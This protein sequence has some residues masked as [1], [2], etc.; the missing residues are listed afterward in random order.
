MTVTRTKATLVG[1][2][3]ILS[4]GLLALLAIGSA[5]VPPMQLNALC[6]AT[7][8]AIGLVWTGF[9]AGFVVLRA[10]PW[11]VYL[12][13]TLGLFGAHFLY[14]TAIRW[15]PMAETSLIGYLWPLFIVLLS[16]L[17]PGEK[18][19]PLHVVGALLAFGG[20]A[21]I[22]LRG[23]AAL[24][25]GAWPGFAMA[26]AFALT[27]A[28]YSVGSR[29]FGTQPSEAVT[30]YFLAGALLSVVAHL[31]T[32]T[33]VWPDG[34]LGWLAILGLGI[35]PVGAA[36]FAWD[37]GMKHGDIQLL[38]VAAYAAPLIS[39]LVLILVGI[40]P[41]TATIFGAA[42]LIVGGAALAARARKPSG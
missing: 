42:A 31:A 3:A 40:T 9:G 7:G 11:P 27:W 22:V 39:T 15:A 29:R 2:A 26:F 36:F 24:P 32:E 14:F 18:L 4:W 25:P 33:T 37:I 6:F 35:G 17:L 23:G 10:V 30:V 20:A 8:G 1:F 19:R 21:L 38:G 34:T 16:S 12:F 28:G 5:P 13:G 41:V